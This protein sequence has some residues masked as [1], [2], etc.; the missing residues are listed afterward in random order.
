MGGGVLVVVF[1]IV[2]SVV[3]VVVL[4]NVD[5]FVSGG[6]PET[7]HWGTGGGFGGGW[8][9]RV[10]WRTRGGSPEKGRFW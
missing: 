4:V 1:F 5:W 10:R 7:G 3:I 9:T 6:V 2:Y 8:V